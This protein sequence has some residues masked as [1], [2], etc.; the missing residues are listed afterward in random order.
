MEAIAIPMTIGAGVYLLRELTQGQRKPIDPTD[1]FAAENSLE[2][3]EEFLRHQSRI[4]GLPAPQYGSP[5][6]APPWDVNNAPDILEQTYNFPTDATPD[7]V[8]DVVINAYGHARKDWMAAAAKGLQVPARTGNGPL[9]IAFTPE[10]HDNFRRN[11]VTQHQSWGWLP[12]DA[13]DSDVMDAGRMAKAIP[14]N[15][16]LY[17]PDAF[18]VTAPGLPYR[19]SNQ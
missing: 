15:P 18:F 4:Y 10:L 6:F 1:E 11:Q 14:P 9:W 16:L 8:R 5:L 3:P 12:N 13:T 19:Y 2:T 17:T 7:G